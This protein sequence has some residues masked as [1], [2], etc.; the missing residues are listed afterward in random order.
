MN[1]GGSQQ[2]ARVEVIIPSSAVTI[3]TALILPQMSRHARG[4]SNYSGE[5]HMGALVPLS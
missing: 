1:N 2:V 4:C 5:V 3:C